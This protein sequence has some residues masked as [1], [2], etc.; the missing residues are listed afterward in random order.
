MTHLLMTHDSTTHVL[1]HSPTQVGIARRRLKNTLCARCGIGAI[2][3]RLL[4]QG[5]GPNAPSRAG[6]SAPAQALHGDACALVLHSCHEHAR[7][8]L[9]TRC[10]NFAPK[11]NVAALFRT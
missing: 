1:M 3:L 4:N 8:D 5:E 2:K 9:I 7:R 6:V 10:K 11:W